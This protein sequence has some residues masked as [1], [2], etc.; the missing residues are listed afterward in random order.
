M[1]ARQ[2][3]K[4]NGFTLVELVM[5]IV[6]ISLLSYGGISLFTS[7]SAYSGFV[8]KD[9][10][11][12]QSLLAQQVALGSAGVANPVTLTVAVDAGDNWVFTLQKSGVSNPNAVSVES[13][14]NSMQ[15]DGVTFSSGGSRT[16]T[17][18]NG[19]E[20]TPATNHEIRF[21]GTNAFRVCLSAQ[22]YAYES[23]VACP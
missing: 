13:S 5:V 20:L 21:T 1:I 17:W 18:T 12:S 11:I 22:G 6:V 15:I 9:A 7:Q 8:A 3:K 23:S 4:Q 16:F 10:L 14:G 19:A 2:T